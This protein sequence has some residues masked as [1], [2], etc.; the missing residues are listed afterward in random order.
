MDAKFNPARVEYRIESCQKS[1]SG[2]TEE[3]LPAS[4]KVIVESNE[5]E[6][7]FTSG[8]DQPLD[9]EAQEAL[10]VVLSA[11]DPDSPTDDEIFGTSGRK[12]VGDKWG[13]NA[14]AAAR[15]FSKRG[16][17]VSATG[18]KGSVQLDRV[19][20]V[21]AVK[22]LE[23]SARLRMEGMKMP[24]P[25]GMTLEKAVMEADFIGLVPADPQSRS[26]LPDKLRIQANILMGG[27]KPDT[28]EKIAIE[29]SMERSLENSY[30][31]I[32]EDSKSQ[33]SS[34]QLPPPSS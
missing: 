9:A 8:G 34:N 32:Q 30:P 23:I 20:T 10:K 21:G 6:T 16:I 15:D 25:E 5:G 17:P 11:H 7:V 4:R 1:S 3:V 28:G 19:R 33:S 29:F 13:I 24:A 2:K 18:I 12:R 22:A 26:L 14:V 31:P 27:Q